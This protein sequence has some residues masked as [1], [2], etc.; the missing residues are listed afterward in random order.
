[1]KFDNALPEPGANTEKPTAICWEVLKSNVAFDAKPWLSVVREQVRLPSGRL[2]DDFYRIRLH[3]F[4]VVMPL[5]GDGQWIFVRGYKHGPRCETLSPPAGLMEED[6]TPLAAAKRE[7]LEETGCT[8]DSWQCL[9]QF[10]VDVNRHC[11]S[12]HL[13]L[14]RGVREVQLPAVDD[15]EPLV[16]ER[17]SIEA[18]SAALKE[19]Q[20]AGLAAAAAV[21]I[22]MVAA[23]LSPS[24]AAPIPAG[25]GF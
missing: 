6:E 19:G 10:V 3:D 8:A 16:V 21:S 20:I 17:I 7:L 13:F 15:G 22:A 18:A 25:Q 23:Q 11:G 5:A 24:K 9:G 14:A 4:V 12:M 2:L 1:M